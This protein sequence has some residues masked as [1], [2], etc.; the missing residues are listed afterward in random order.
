MT[1]SFLHNLLKDLLVE[2]G[3]NQLVEVDQTAKLHG[4]LFQLFADWS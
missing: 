4:N 2:R 1:F 3:I